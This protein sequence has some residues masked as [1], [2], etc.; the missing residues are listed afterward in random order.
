MMKL[1]VSLMF[2]N[3]G[4]LHGD[5]IIEIKLNSVLRDEDVPCQEFNKI[6]N[7]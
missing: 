6:E 3:I 7:L 4:T 2:R 5:Y 1:V